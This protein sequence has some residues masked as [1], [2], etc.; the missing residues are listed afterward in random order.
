MTR[1]ESTGPLAGIKVIEFAGIGPGPFAATMLADLG[2]TVL[3]IERPGGTT[4]IMPAPLDPLRRGRSA[5]SLD[6][7]DPA[8]VARA[9]EL[10]ESADVLIEGNRPGVMERLGLGPQECLAR[11][12]R[13]VYGRVTGWGQ[14]G[15]LAPRAGHDI[16]YLAIT[17]A[18]HT[19]GRSG[20]APSIPTNMLGDFAGG[21]MF[22]VS[23]VLA[24]VIEAGRS[25]RGQ[26]VDAA[27]VDGTLAF[28][29]T[30]HGLLAVDQ[31]VDQRGVNLLD[32]GRPWYEVY[33]TSD[34]RHLAVG[35]IEPKFYAEFMAVLGLVADE[36]ERSDPAAWPALRERIA[37]VIRTRSRDEW[38]AVFEP[39][40]AC[41]APVLSLT[42]AKAHAHLVARGSFVE[43]GGVEQPVP[44]PRFDRTAP[45]CP[46]APVP[47]DADPRPALRR[48]G[49]RDVE[50][51]LA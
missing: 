48:W 41:V 8:D 20:A 10:V 11:N 15:P 35:A 14:T 23:G 30:L 51:F 16:G 43:I 21:S 13:L 18:L 44:A 19:I 37:G 45:G 49:V 9:L 2:A 42:E 25:G 32:S 40:D 39:T 29:L 12:P 24:A 3:R 22:L 50:A 47:L 38:A 1:H 4:S 33:E 27:I 26:V 34:G 17:G 6:L 31:W 5:L 36:S 46:A 28:T 7:R